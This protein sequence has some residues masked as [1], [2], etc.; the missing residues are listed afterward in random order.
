M[1]GPDML[2]VRRYLALGQIPLLR[3]KHA[4]KPK[5][6]ASSEDD[7]NLEIF[8]WTENFENPTKYATI[9]HVWSDGFGNEEE[10]EL[11]RC[12][13]RFIRRL[14]DNLGDDGAQGWNTPFW[15]D[16]LVIPVGQ[17]KE[18]EDLRK[19][20]I[21]QIFQVFKESSYTIVLDA[22]LSQMNPGSTD[23]PAVAAMRILGS[24][25][26]RRLWTL[27]EAFLSRKIYFAFEENYRATSYLKEFSGLS[28]KLGSKNETEVTITPLLYSH[29][30]VRALLYQ[31]HFTSSKTRI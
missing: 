16:T 28:K 26:M 23:R 13:L 22:G 8:T 3:F 1:H 17:G 24:S 6:T 29:K 10:N 19:R 14:L 30:V 9:S 20:A 11:H 25:W 7:L 12:Q 15:M 5:N 27:Q 31:R 2:I 21:K 4:P 18:E